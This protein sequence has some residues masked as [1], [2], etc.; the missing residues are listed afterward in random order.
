MKIRKGPA[1]GRSGARKDS[2]LALRTSGAVTRPALQASAA[3]ISAAALEMAGLRARFGVPPAPPEGDD[4]LVVVIDRDVEVRA[5]LLRQI[6]PR[7]GAGL[8]A[9]EET[10]VS[11]ALLGRL[12]G[13]YGE[14]GEAHLGA[15]S[16][17]RGVQGSRRVLGRSLR[18]LMDR[19]GR[20]ARER[21]EALPEGSP[22]RARLQEDLA[23]IDA[24]EAALRAAQQG[25]AER[26]VAEQAEAQREERA[27]QQRERLS[28][29]LHALR[30][31]R[32]VPQAAVAEA[33]ETL[34]A[35][36]AEADPLAAEDAD[37]ADAAALDRRGR[38]R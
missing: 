4:D 21:V 37:D 27:Q 8:G 7:G 35:Q 33:A 32:P 10:G 26:T 14:L 29:V 20:A 16:L 19:L 15:L 12:L 36:E 5:H 25:R 24:R 17:R 1:A 34:A 28:A 11:A 18:T 9:E 31:G 3:D 2:A 30:E 13:Q 6:L 23:E 22:E 38:D